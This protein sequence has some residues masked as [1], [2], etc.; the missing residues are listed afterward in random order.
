MA[1]KS[2]RP[3]L[4]TNQFEETLTF[5]TKVLGF[6]I[7]ER[8]NEWGWASLYKDTVHIMV[9]KP[10]AHT[11]FEKPIFTGSFY[12]NTDQVDQLWSQLKDKTNICYEL[13]DFEWEMREFGI[14]DNNGY[15]LQ[16]GQNI[17]E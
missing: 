9:A 16:F 8:N 5:Y 12:F 2:L 11:P 4:W 1:L 7:G 17:E 6:T 10:N 15:L 3:M 14:Y 13:E